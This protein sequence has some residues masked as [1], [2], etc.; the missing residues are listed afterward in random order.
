[1]MKAELLKLHATEIMNICSVAFDFLELEI[2]LRLGDNLL[3]ID[4][5]DAGSL[6]KFAGTAAPAGPDTQTHVADWQ[7][8]CWYNIDDADERLHPIEFMSHILTKHAALQIRQDNVR[9]RH[10]S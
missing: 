9:G 7:L 10:Y 8:R 5:Y 3:F 4:A 6:V 1:M 2:H